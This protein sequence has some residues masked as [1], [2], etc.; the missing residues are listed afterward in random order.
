MK[1]VALRTAVLSGLF[2]YKNRTQRCRE[3]RKRTCCTGHCAVYFTDLN[4]ALR[5]YAEEVTVTMKVRR[6]T[7]SSLKTWRLPCF[8]LRKLIFLWVNR[9][10]ARKGFIEVSPIPS[11]ECSH[12][13]QL[14]FSSHFYFSSCRA[15]GPANH[16][17]NYNDWWI[18]VALKSDLRAE[19]NEYLSWTKV[20]NQVICISRLP[21]SMFRTHL[22]N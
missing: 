22:V 13:S 8:A 9:H 7:L 3:R 15:S 21:I 20:C 19:T 11:S 16:N 14:L 10:A 18:N 4:A 6:I 2:S 12:Q 1:F 17:M 5:A